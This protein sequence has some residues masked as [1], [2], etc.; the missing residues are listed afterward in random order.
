M[1]NAGVSLRRFGAGSPPRSPALPSPV[2][3]DRGLAWTARSEFR[4]ADR[5]YSHRKDES[6]G[7]RYSDAKVSGCPLIGPAGRRQ[8]ILK[9]GCDVGECVWYL[10]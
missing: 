3:V 7:R 8:R 5:E 2:V 6:K 9:V 1:E 10:T 4:S